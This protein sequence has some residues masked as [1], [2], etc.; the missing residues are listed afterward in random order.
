[1]ATESRTLSER[2][3]SSWRMLE[4]MP[5]YQ[6]PIVLGGALAAL[7]GVVAFGLNIVGER[8]FGID[9]ARA[10]FLI[11]FGGLG[12]IGYVVSKAN[13]RNGMIVA[14]IAGLALMAM[15]GGSV[16]LLTGLLVLVGALWGFVKSL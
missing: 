7:V 5:V 1:M 8:A 6:L 9:W 12:L 3:T 2:A 13:M 15:A 16:G 11:V 14:G 10:L 4:R